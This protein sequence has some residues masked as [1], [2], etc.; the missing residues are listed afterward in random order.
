M[1]TQAQEKR[2]QKQTVVS[3]VVINEFEPIKSAVCQ[4]RKAKKKPEE[5]KE[6]DGQQSFPAVTEL[7]EFI[8]D[9]GDENVDEGELGVETE[10]DQ[11]DEK[12]H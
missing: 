8:E 11:H 2:Q 3:A 12:Q 10:G 9:T 4:N 6:A 1:N 5:A 7:W